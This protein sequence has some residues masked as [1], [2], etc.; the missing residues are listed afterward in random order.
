MNPFTPK[1]HHNLNSPHSINTPTDMMSITIREN[2]NR[3]IILCK[4][5]NVTSNSWNEATMRN[6]FLSV[7]R[8]FLLNLEVHELIN[9]N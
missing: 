2:L 1:T 4:K 9:I 3:R 6:I 5:R 7:G 8:I